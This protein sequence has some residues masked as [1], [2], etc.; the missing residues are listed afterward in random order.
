[1]SV[2]SVLFVHLPMPWGVYAGLAAPAPT[3]RRS[4]LHPGEFMRSW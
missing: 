1:M 4:A 2:Q 3:R